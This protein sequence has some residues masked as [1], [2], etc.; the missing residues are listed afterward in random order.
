[1]GDKLKSRTVAR[2]EGGQ[3]TKMTTVARFDAG[4]IAPAA[5]SVGGRRL[6]FSSLEEEIKELLRC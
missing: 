1:M 6:S 3:G 5:A 2:F 4:S